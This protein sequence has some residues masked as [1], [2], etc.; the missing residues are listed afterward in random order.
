MQTFQFTLAGVRL[1]CVP[2]FSDTCHF[3]ARDPSASS[4]AEQE[5][6]P[7]VTIP[8]SHWSWLAEQGGV[9]DAVAEYSELSFFCSEAL[10]P[11]QRVVIHAAAVRWHDRAWLICGMSGVG[12]STQVH[13]LQ[14]LRPGEF[15]VICGDRPVLEFQNERIL[16]HPS[17][18]NGKEGWRGADAAPLAGVILLT[19]G[20]ENKL[21]PLPEVYAAV[22]LFPMLFF[23]G[24]DVERI[25]QAA[26]YAT[27][28]IRAVPRWLLQTYQVPDSTRLLL[29]TVFPAQADLPQ[30]PSE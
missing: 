2:R 28:L 29:E 16:V 12:K 11:F 9:A 15:S 26:D 23:S 5:A 18:W 30:Q 17:V 8:Q 1:T 13:W 24:W 3:F 25:K 22:S 7:P 21:S 14:A 20:K 19:R 27:R 10:M 4:A 6:A